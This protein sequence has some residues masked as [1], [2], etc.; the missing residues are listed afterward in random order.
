MTCHR[1]S[2]IRQLRFATDFDRALLQL[3]DIINTPFN[4]GILGDIHHWNM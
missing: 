3:V 1:N 4:L 2:L